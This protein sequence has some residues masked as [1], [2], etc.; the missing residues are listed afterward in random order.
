MKSSSCCIKLVIVSVVV[1]FRMSEECIH[2]SDG[3]CGLAC[4]CQSCSSGEPPTTQI[5]LLLP[6]RTTLRRP[7]I[8]PSGKTLTFVYELRGFPYL[9][10]DCTLILTLCVLGAGW[11]TAY[12][13]WRRSSRGCDHQLTHKLDPGNWRLFSAPPIPPPRPWNVCSAHHSHA[14]SCFKD[15]ALR[16]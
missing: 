15:I 16:K 2:S 4:S 7:K 12:F 1:I 6:L 5:W 11:A 8:F 13:C 10:T 3:V 14:R 9:Y